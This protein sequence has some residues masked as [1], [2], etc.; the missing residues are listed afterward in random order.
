MF[1]SIASAAS[2]TG[3]VQ[4][5]DGSP[6]P[7]VIRVVGTQTGT[8]ADS[9]GKF[10]I[11]SSTLRS[12]SHQIEV[13]MFS[14]KTKIVTASTLRPTAV[15][16][17]I[18]PIDLPEVEVTAPLI[19]IKA[20]IQG[21]KF[22][23]IYG[24]SNLQEVTNPNQEILVNTQ[25]IISFDASKTN[26]DSRYFTWY[27]LNRRDYDT[28]STQP[29]EEITSYLTSSS[30]SKIQSRSSFT[31][32]FEEGEHAVVLQ[33][34]DVENDKYY[35]EVI[36][37]KSS[38]TIEPQII[39]PTTQIPRITQQP[40]IQQSILISNL[41]CIQSIEP[42]VC[43]PTNKNECIAN[44]FYNNP[45]FNN[46][47]YFNTQEQSMITGSV[48]ED[49]TTLNQNEC[50]LNQPNKIRVYSC[51]G[52]EGLVQDCLQD[53]QCIKED[54]VAMCKKTIKCIDYPHLE[55]NGNTDK[56]V[57]LW[58]K[59]PNHITTFNNQ[60]YKNECIENEDKLS[61]EDVS[62]RAKEAAKNSEKLRMEAR[63]TVGITSM[64]IFQ[65]L[66]D[67]NSD[68]IINP[69]METSRKTE[70]EIDFLTAAAFQEGLGFE[71]KSISISQDGKSDFS[72]ANLGMDR[73]IDE[74]DTLKKEGFLRSDF[75]G[76]HDDHKYNRKL[77]EYDDYY[78]DS[79]KKDHPIF[80]SVDSA[81]EAFAAML[82]QRR[83]I[84]FNDLEEIGID[85]NTLTK[86][87]IFYWTYLYYN[88]GA[89]C[90]KNRIK[91]DGIEI[92]KGIGS[93]SATSANR[94]SKLVLGIV[95]QIRNAGLFDPLNEVKVHYCDNDE[96]KFVI[97]D[98]KGNLCSI[99]SDVGI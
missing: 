62:N 89:N 45:R 2:I 40:I 8:Q 13:S 77:S 94:N 3:T 24:T 78:Y 29:Q 1:A 41:Y 61:A 85:K 52:E 39:S 72:G 9:Q 57:E 15:I 87:Q 35:F 44:P 82:L 56:V 58:R 55:G 50:I 23:R 22:N 6:L 81:L 64:S 59:D 21:D 7:A 76:F 38:S 84:F 42:T 97:V 27:I 4:D 74:E 33:I 30:K 46:K 68:K 95:Y 14:Y 86:D 75:H 34:Q 51:D 93:N 80:L 48:T 88:C 43:N 36:Y 71:V 79:I 11:S 37:I 49:S 28:I 83:N 19:K 47:V 98:D 26:K 73:F 53:Q 20:Q 66:D 12:G 92:P 90:G 91:K 17:E 5:Q 10:S 31:S 65:F 96:L 54:N 63:E 32:S 60:V 70:I 18:N 67:P 25:D 69:L 99:K 16:L